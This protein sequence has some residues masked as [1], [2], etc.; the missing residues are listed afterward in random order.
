MRNV[1]H[2]NSQSDTYRRHPQR[3]DRNRA[4]RIHGTGKTP[5]KS[6]IYAT[7]ELGF[8]FLTTPDCNGDF[9]WMANRFLRFDDDLDDS[10]LKKIEKS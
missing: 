7:Y 4:K 8:R 9:L 2:P 1:L 6:I 5:W 10:G 3:K